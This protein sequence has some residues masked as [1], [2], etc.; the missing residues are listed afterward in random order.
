M[1]IY[2]KDNCQY[3]DRLVT[4]LDKRHI[5]YEKYQLDEDFT[6]DEFLT[7][8]GNGATFP[9]VVI[10]DKV[11]GGLRETAEYLIKQSK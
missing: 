7:M 9:R 11:I 2:T 5:E 6:R 3:C 1:K 4:V 8:F 10:E